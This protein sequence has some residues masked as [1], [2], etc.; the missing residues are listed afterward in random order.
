MIYYRFSVLGKVKVNIA[1]EK[2]RVSD[3][4]SVTMPVKGRY[5]SQDLLHEHQEHLH[6]IHKNEYSYSRI[7]TNENDVL[8]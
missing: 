8:A 4:N 3:Y 2:K 7:P 6:L 5:V 1:R